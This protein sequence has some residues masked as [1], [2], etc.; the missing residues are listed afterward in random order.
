MQTSDQTYTF[1]RKLLCAYQ[2]IIELNVVGMYPFALLLLLETAQLLFFPFAIPQKSSELYQSFQKSLKA[3]LY[4]PY[5]L[6]QF[7]SQAFFLL[8]AI[9]ASVLVLTAGL[10]LLVILKYKSAKIVPSFIGKMAINVLSLLMV[11]FKTV[12]PIP[13]AF[14]FSVPL[15][16]TAN[17]GCWAGA[18]LPVSALSIFCLILLLALIFA[19][20]EFVDSYISSSLP[21]AAPCSSDGFLIHIVKYAIGLF[22]AID[23]EMSIG[24][25]AFIV[26]I[27]VCFYLIYKLYYTLIPY[28]QLVAYMEC[29]KQGTFTCCL[30]G[31]YINGLG[32][33]F[34]ELDT[35][36]III[37]LG[38]CTSW[39]I[40]FKRNQRIVKTL[41]N[42]AVLMGDENDAVNALVVL[43]R[44]HTQVGKRN[45]DYLCFLI[46]SLNSHRAT[47][48]NPKCVCNLLDKQG[49]SVVVGGQQNQSSPDES[50]FGHVSD[51]TAD[52]D[53][54]RWLE[55]I[56]VLLDEAVGKFPSS[57]NLRLLV[58]YYQESRYHNMYKAF[59][60]LLKA[61]EKEC[62]IEQELA[63]YSMTVMLNK[64][65]CADESAS[66]SGV[67]DVDIE[68]FVTIEEKR[69]QFELAIQ[70]CTQIVLE[71]W[72]L[73]LSL[74]LRID[75]MYELGGKISTSF[76]QV[77]GYFNSIIDIFPDHVKTYLMYSLFLH[78]VANS[79][80]EAEEYQDKANQI[81]KSIDS[82]KRQTY[83]MENA[84]SVNRETA[85]FIISGELDTLGIVLNANEDTQQIFGYSYNEL[86]GYS[87]NKIMPKILAMS[88]DRFLMR[89][90]ETGKH[91]ML[92]KESLL[93]GQ[94]KF[95]LLIPI[96]VLMKTMP[97]LDEG[98]RYISF[99]RKDLHYIKKNLIRLPYQYQSQKDINF[100]MTDANGNIQGISEHTARTFGIPLEYFERKRALFSEAMD[101]RQLNR[102]QLK[103]ESSVGE[104]L[105][106]GTIMEL[107]LDCVYNAIDR[108][109]LTLEE[110]AELDKQRSSIEM[111]V[112][113]MIYDLEYEAKYRI[114][115]FVKT[116]GH[117][118]DNM[119][120]KRSTK[121][122]A[123]EELM[124]D[125]FGDAASSS[126]S[127]SI[128]KND[129]LRVVV[130]ELKKN[131]FEHNESSKIKLIKRL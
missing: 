65:I 104:Q 117:A 30:I 85:I 62:T 56:G 69:R 8:W 106:K 48:A 68:M 27:L 20:E 107:N 21:W 38:V 82:S 23:Y 78:D 16:C 4:A 44:I 19:V 66:T 31:M 67:I 87:I 122:L 55:F 118:S 33:S 93:F 90:Y 81:L 22:L 45:L 119:Q 14:T 53:S 103:L 102:K 37:L 32:G 28:S 50:S 125:V 75:R 6:D 73:L 94:S 114:F 128:A 88:H 1:K 124:D 108:D 71:F 110:S 113:Q 112:Q 25:Y 111:Y 72:R 127:S 3:M 18:D 98:L 96:A 115:V 49:S 42:G 34:V 7:G 40:C 70:E 59:F 15:F 36:I 10:L 52:S 29:I 116:K 97:G 41:H 120:I 58:S 100:I 123:E 39:L 17:Y 101:I 79:E 24:Q 57:V 61:V 84:F 2:H 43:S 131:I 63:V 60:Q 80:I 126:A 54:H 26:L 83:A 129:K 12:L 99:I 5:I 13:M 11:L 121:E 9:H 95:G 130:K 47:C 35:S 86:V 109:F 92:N 77:H 76:K 105:K 64:A 91:S 74:N 46:G 51:R 89:F